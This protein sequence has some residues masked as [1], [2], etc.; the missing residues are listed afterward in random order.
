MKHTLLISFEVSVTLQ[1]E[2]V[3]RVGGLVCASIPCDIGVTEFLDPL[4]TGAE[5]TG[6]EVTAEAKSPSK[7]VCC[8]FGVA[9]RTSSTF[10]SWW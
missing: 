8:S 3:L 10:S 2:D 5:V 7:G 9:L 4:F 6:A 1:A